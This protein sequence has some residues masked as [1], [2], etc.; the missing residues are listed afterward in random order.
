MFIKLCRNILCKNTI[1]LRLFC[2]FQ[3]AS[4][5]LEAR[6]EERSSAHPKDSGEKEQSLLHR[7]AAR[8][9]GVSH[10]Q[11]ESQEDEGQHGVRW[12]QQDPQDA[13]EDQIQHSA[14]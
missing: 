12:T 6:E 13:G 8:R 4:E 2:S 9:H 5:S 3:R 10:R 1:T 11:Q 7:R 14:S